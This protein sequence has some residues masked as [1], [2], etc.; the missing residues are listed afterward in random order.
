VDH[1][2]ICGLHDCYLIEGSLTMI[3]DL[4]QGGELFDR[5]VA[6]EHYSEKEARA[7]FAQVV[8]AVGHCHRHEVVHRDVKPENL[9][10]AELEGHPRGGLLKLC[11]FGLATCLA[12]HHRLHHAC[13]SPAY[14]SPE[15]FKARTSGGGYSHATDLWSCGCVLYV[16]LCGYT[17]FGDD[18]ALITAGAFAFHEQYW[19][20][21]SAAARETVSLLL[22][23]DP[24]K[25]PTAEDVFKAPWMTQD[26]CDKHI[27]GFSA[28]WQKYKLRRKFKSA[29]LAVLAEHRFQDHVPTDGLDQQITPPSRLSSGDGTAESQDPLA[30]RSTRTRSF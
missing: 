10:Y 16:L 30:Y 5:I 11:D 8:E 18:P 9:L 17:P 3:L 15:I 14:C 22:A 12:P 28:T 23:T 21:I 13:G 26:P 20:S 4:C 24:Q 7:A 27:P 2:N 1:P 25:R 29:V 6:K 19:R